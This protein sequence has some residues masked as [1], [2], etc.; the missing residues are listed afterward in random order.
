MVLLA[1]KIYETGSARA[2][3]GGSETDGDVRTKKAIKMVSLPETCNIQ[4]GP[5]SK[6]Q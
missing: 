1:L 5:S 2:E 6:T 3:V 4:R